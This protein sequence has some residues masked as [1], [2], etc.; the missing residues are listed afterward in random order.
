MN[1]LAIDP[2]SDQ[3]AWVLLN[4]ETREVLDSGIEGNL[5]MV[6]SLVATMTEMDH[7]AIE[8]IYRRGMPLMQQAIDTVW[9]CGRFVQ[10]WGSDAYSLM[11]RRDV[12]WCICRDQRAKDANIRAALVDMYGGK[13]KGIGRKASP[14]PLY[15]LKADMW[16]ALAIGITWIMQQEG[17]RW[18]S[19]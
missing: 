18:Q 8:Y 14:G 11:D 16:S 12:K 17:G 2:G 19:G 13:E 6:D 10:A 15:G 7:M 5:D 9:W 4:T 3:S 1:L